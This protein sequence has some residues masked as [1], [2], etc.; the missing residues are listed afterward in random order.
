V[1][2]ESKFGPDSDP[3]SDS[4]L[5][6]SLAVSFYTHDPREP[7]FAAWKRILRYVHGTFDHG[8]Q[9]HVSTTTQL[10]AYTD[11]DWAGCPVTRR[12][13]SECYVFLR[14]IL[15]SWSAKR[16]VTLLRSS[17]EAEYKGLAN[18]VA[19]TA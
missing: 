3:V 18:V 15:L 1:D 13:T 11:A 16:Q 7:H 10:T 17:V 12:S 5:Y 9:L 8:L 19:E 2:T 6:R 4:T 14:D